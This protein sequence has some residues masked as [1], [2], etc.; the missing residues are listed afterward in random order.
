MRCKLFVVC[1]LSYGVRCLSLLVDADWSLLLLCAVCCL[2]YDV[3][4]LSC[5]V[6]WCCLVFVDV[7]CMVLC[8]MMCIV[9][10]GCLLALRVAVCCC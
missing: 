4:C 10:C 1:C 7:Y 8:C 2:L 5:V 9:C 3:N 6:V